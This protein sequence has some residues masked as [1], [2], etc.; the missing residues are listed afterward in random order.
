MRINIKGTNIE[1]TPS[2]LDYL[3][4]RLQSLD[5]LVHNKEEA[6]ILDVEVGRTTKHHASG[7]VFRA[8]LNIHIGSK[9]FR[10]VR[11]S[12]DLYSSIDEAKS[13]MMDELRSSK[14]KKLHLLRRGGQRV[15]AIIKG[16]YWWRK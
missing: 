3:N 8:E 15:K 9:S 7:D 6:A 12:S 4:K 11:E 5:K 14:G 2:L 10:A 16:L 1:L 13:Q